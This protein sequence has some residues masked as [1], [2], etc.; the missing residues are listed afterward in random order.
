MSPESPSVF[1]PQ[2]DRGAP[3]KCTAS[4]LNEKLEL[5]GSYATASQKYWE[6]LTLPQAAGELD[7]K[8]LSPQVMEI[9]NQ[10]GRN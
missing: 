2:Q 1:K 10:F 5:R 7:R 6:R 4:D 3:E 9:L 8:A